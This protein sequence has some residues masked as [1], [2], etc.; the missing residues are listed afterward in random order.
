MKWLADCTT[1]NEVKDQLSLYNVIDLEI[2]PNQ[3]HV[4]YG[5]ERLS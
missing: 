3:I 4:A 5:K 1:V 2:N